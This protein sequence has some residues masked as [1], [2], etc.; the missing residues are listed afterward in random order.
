MKRI[1]LLLLTTWGLNSF[2]QGT[3]ELFSLRLGYSSTNIAFKEAFEPAYPVF[4]KF[5]RAGKT[6]VGEG[7]DFGVSKSI[8]NKMYIELGYSPFSG[9]DMQLKVGSATGSVEY[10]YTLKGFQL[11]LTFNYLLRDSSKKLRFNLGT[12]L[13]YLSGHLQQFVK[14]DDNGVQQTSQ[15]EDIRISEMSLI[16]R[17]GIQYQIFQNLVASFIVKVSLAPN[18]R[19]AD[20][21]AFSLKYTFTRY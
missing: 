14:A 9:E 3:D 12:G 21:P 13:Q 16:L 1:F 8:N 17:P 10:T 15:I 6:F 11:P 5:F 20:G 18:G 7:I 4:S 19:Y 2:G